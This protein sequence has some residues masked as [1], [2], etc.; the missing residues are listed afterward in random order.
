MIN[1][2][3]SLNY[4][5]SDDNKMT[6]QWRLASK[7]SDFDCST[8]NV[9]LSL[10]QVFPG[11]PAWIENRTANIVD[12]ELT[13]ETPLSACSSYEFKI[14]GVELKDPRDKKRRTVARPTADFEIQVEHLT[15]SSFQVILEKQKLCKDFEVEV[16]NSKG[17]N[18]KRSSSY[19][20]NVNEIDSCENYSTR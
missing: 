5:L 2:I 20:T 12:Y 16:T 8:Q 11:A 14:D 10:I 18:V 4:T 1:K 15:L 7:S 3:T 13:F 19:V 9:T 6:V 17:A